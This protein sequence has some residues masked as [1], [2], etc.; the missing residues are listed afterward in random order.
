MPNILLIVIALLLF[1]GPTRRRIFGAWRFVVPAVLG[2]VIACMLIGTLVC[3]GTIPAAIVIA[4]PI[5]AALAIGSSC[6][7]WFHDNFPPRRP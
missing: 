5:T 2:G 3:A 4:V 1:V 6:R 7:Q